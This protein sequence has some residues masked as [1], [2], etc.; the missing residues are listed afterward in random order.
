M[1]VFGVFG[2]GAYRLRLLHVDDM[3]RPM[4]ANENTCVDAVGR[5]GFTYRGPAEALARIIG[6]KRACPRGWGR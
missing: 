2:D 5:E 4:I 3:T 1:P 6:V